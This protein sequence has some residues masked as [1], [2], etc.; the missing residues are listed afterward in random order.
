[1]IES[2]STIC[3]RCR[4]AD[5]VTRSGPLMGLCITCLENDHIGAKAEA[6]LLRTEIGKLH[7]FLEDIQSACGDRQRFVLLGPLMMQ[8]ILNR[9]GNA[10]GGSRARI[11]LS[12]SAGSGEK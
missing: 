6:G 9:I 11:A 4:E 12:M 3:T 1:M 5:H 8:S 2:R 10:L 7:D